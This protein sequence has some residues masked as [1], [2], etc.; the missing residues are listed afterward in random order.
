MQRSF[1]KI[2]TRKQKSEKKIPPTQPKSAGI[3]LTT[4]RGGVFDLS[5]FELL[6]L[7]FQ[8]FSLRG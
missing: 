3:T 7:K 1:L 6:L 4:G 8:D 5:R 2:N